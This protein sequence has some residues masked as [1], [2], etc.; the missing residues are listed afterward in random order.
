MRIGQWLSCMNTTCS[1][2]Y[3]LRIERFEIIKSGSPEFSHFSIAI[4]SA[5]IEILSHLVDEIIHKMLV[6]KDLVAMYK[7]RCN[8]QLS[9]WRALRQKMFLKLFSS[10]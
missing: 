1:D 9:K 2:I 8:V 5:M 4:F 7:D 6:A 3:Y 10:E